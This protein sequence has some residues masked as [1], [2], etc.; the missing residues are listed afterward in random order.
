M[1]I[2]LTRAN[3][4][5]LVLHPITFFVKEGIPSIEVK[6]CCDGALLPGIGIIRN[7]QNWATNEQGNRIL[8]LQPAMKFSSY[9]VR[10]R[11]ERL[12]M[13]PFRLVGYSPRSLL[14]V[15][16]TSTSILMK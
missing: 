8:P 14:R 1:Q 5:P 2:D 6:D 13:L 12:L 11:Q 10:T 9:V 7:A 4:Q 15:H 3:I 16:Y